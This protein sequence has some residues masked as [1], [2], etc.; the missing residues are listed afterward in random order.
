MW[1]NFICCLLLVTTAQPNVKTSIA[2]QLGG[3]RSPEGAKRLYHRTK[4]TTWIWHGAPLSKGP[5]IKY[6]RKI[7]GF[8]DPLPPVRKST[9]P[10]LLSFSTMS[11]FGPTP[12]PPLC[13]RTLWMAPYST[14]NYGPSLHRADV[15]PWF[16]EMGGVFTEI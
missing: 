8:L 7:F 2:V 10:P 13:G 1:T 12:S 11:A 9:Q 3:G 14:E 4:R 5:S 16:L 15:A 6:V